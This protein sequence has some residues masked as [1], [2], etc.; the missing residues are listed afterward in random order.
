VMSYSNGTNN[1]FVDLSNAGQNASATDSLGTS[2]QTTSINVG[3]LTKGANGAAVNATATISVGAG[4]SYANTAQGLINAINNSGLGLTAAF[5]TASQAGS[6]AVASAL[7]GSATNSALKTSANDTG[8]AISGAGVGVNNNSAAAGY[9]NGVGEVGALT[10][11]NAGD[12]LSGT[13]TIVGSDG[14]SHAMVLGTANSTDTLANLQ[15]TI[16]AAGWGVTASLNANSVTN[17]SGIHAANTVLTFTSADSQVTV[18][19]TSMVDGEVTQ[20]T[21]ALS[22]TNGGT[23]TGAGVTLASMTVAAATDTLTGGI[24]VTGDGTFGQIN[25]NLNGQTLSQIATFVNSH[26]AVNGEFGDITATL[27]NNNTT[28]TFTQTATKTTNFPIVTTDAGGT[29]VITDNSATTG[30]SIVNSAAT[31]AVGGTGSIGTI[32]VTNA[33]DLLTSG[34]ITI[35]GGIGNATTYTLGTA[36]STD[37]LANLMA[38]INANSGASD[39]SAAWTN[40]GHTG[41]TIT[42]TAGTK[43]AGIW[44]NGTSTTLSLAGTPTSNANTT[45]LGTLSLPA[46]GSAAGDT[47]GGT[48]IFGTETINLG[49]STGNQKTN[50]MANLASTINAGNYGV[51]ATLN[52]AGTA[53]TFTSADSVNAPSAT[54]VWPPT[55][56]FKDVTDGN[57]V[58]LTDTSNNELTSSQYY[59]VGISGTVSDT[60]TGGGTG[61]VGLSNDLNGRG[62]VATISYSDAAGQSL[63]QTDLSTQV[64]AQAAL[65]S[66]NTAISDVAAQDGYIGAMI[67]TLNSVSQVLSTQQENVQAAQN[68]VQA[69]DYASATSNMSKYEIL[70]QTGI[71]ALAQANSLQQ[72]VTKLLQ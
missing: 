18:A 33:T 67:N 66:L 53:I 23:G 38:T 44:G 71:S 46:A 21:V 55:G 61:I 69:T 57:A 62:G 39:V 41:L 59:N 32:N 36:G 40:S 9:T 8:I 30:A 2:T 20:P 34:S 6:A 17:A 56:T 1:V 27:S 13:L 4:T 54:A 42:N 10:V 22:L 19:G 25:Y 48:L 35:A 43:Q 58:L 65:T 29:N 24:S 63:S 70:S 16:N 60:S 50:T 49:I 5:T 64:D 68:A 47:L 12:Q 45:T 37:T 3:Y 7:A 52:T 14:A 31:L 26:N 72:E 11:T 28:L 15:S 51:T